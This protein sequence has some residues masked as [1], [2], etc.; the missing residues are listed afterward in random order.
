MHLY[1][2]KRTC[3][4]IAMPT[5]IFES[6]TSSNELS[7]AIFPAETRS[8]LKLTS[9]LYDSMIVVEEW[10]SWKIFQCKRVTREKYLSGRRERGRWNCNTSNLVPRV[11]LFAGYVGAWLW[12]NRIEIVIWLAAAIIN[13]ADTINACFLRELRV[14]IRE[15]KIINVYQIWNA[16]SN[17]INRRI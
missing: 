17:N 8:C 4:R 6:S 9:A 7:F 16:K 11:C 15:E 2:T 14:D 3:R 5:R 1:E 13:A 10:I 12:G